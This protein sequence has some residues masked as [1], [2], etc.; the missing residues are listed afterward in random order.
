MAKSGS[1]NIPAKHN[2]YELRKEKH[3]NITSFFNALLFD[4]IMRKVGYFINHRLKYNA[5]ALYPTFSIINHM[6][7]FYA[8]YFF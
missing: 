7:S 8:K 5:R 6:S 4:L 2:G 1:T 3:Q